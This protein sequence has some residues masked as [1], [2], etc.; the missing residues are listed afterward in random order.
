MSDIIFNHVVTSEKGHYISKKEEM[1]MRPLSRILVFIA[2]L[3]LPIAYFTPIWFIQLWAPQYPE[4]LEMQI[5]INRLSGDV[6]IINGLNHYIGMANIEEAMFPELK[7]LTYV[8]AGIIA[9]GVVTVI[10]NKKWL[11]NLFT[12]ILIAFALAA[13]VDMYL[14]G[15]KYGHN[16]NPHAAIK[17]EGESYQ[18]PLIGYK[19]LLNFLALSAPDKGGIALFG[20]GL[21]AIVAWIYQLIRDRKVK[22][23]LV[24]QLSLVLFSLL[25]PSCSPGSDKINYGVDDCDNCGMKLMDNKFGA[26][27]VNDK[28]K[29]FSFDD[30][31]C[32]ATYLKE[33]SAV[34]FNKKLVAD[35]SVPGTLVE[36]E[37]AVYLKSEEIKSPM[38][39]GIAAFAIPDSLRSIVNEIEGKTLNWQE[40][41]NNTE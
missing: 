32:M 15:Y 12:F 20:A 26:L 34:T 27:L 40:V 17:I 19:Q 41:Q 29:S 14:W 11:L 33:N 39:S 31:N 9:L 25:L 1:N 35:F 2:T 10:A 28:G 16:L 22:R 5:W 21:L 36:A 37:K 30:L 8:L 23:R 4:G 18:P 7:F 38:G 6:T 13:M 3:L 24:N